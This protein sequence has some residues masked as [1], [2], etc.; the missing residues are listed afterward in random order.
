MMKNDQRGSVVFFWLRK[1]GPG[2][3]SPQRVHAG[4]EL[5]WSPCDQNGLFSL[6]LPSFWSLS[7]DFHREL[8]REGYKFP[9]RI[10][11]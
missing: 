5:E 8:T 3:S 2:W 9:L 6:E 7:V 10:D 11:P 1:G 4:R